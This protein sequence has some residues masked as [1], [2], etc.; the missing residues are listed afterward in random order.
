M[1]ELPLEELD[2]RVA[3][4]D[5]LGVRALRDLR[6]SGSVRLDELTATRPV[7]TLSMLRELGERAGREPLAD[8]L[9]AWVRKLT[10]RRVLFGDLARFESAWAAPTLT[11]DALSSSRFSPKRALSEV[12]TCAEPGLRAR[13]ARALEAGA[14]GALEAAR[15]LG[16]RQAEA[17]R[18]LGLDG[19]DALLPCDDRAGVDRAAELVLEKTATYAAPRASWDAA[20]AACL[21]RDAHRGWPAHLTSAWAHGLVRKTGLVDGLVL[22]LGSLPRPLG[23][24]SFARALARLGH[25]F[26]RA[27]APRSAPF[28][29]AMRPFDLRCHRR[30][31]LFGSLAADPVFCH[32]ALG[33]GRVEARDQARQVARALVLTLRLDA[34]RVLVRGM[35]T[36]AARDRQGLWEGS[37]ERALGASIPASLA[38]LVPR[39]SIEDGARFMGTLLG[40]TDR[41]VLIERFD[42]D[43]FR[44]PH[45][46]QALRDEQA[47]LAASANADQA[48]LTQ[49]VSDL[50]RALDAL[51]A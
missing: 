45:A 50:V 37:T 33:L 26:A 36:Q 10:L 20:V 39:S 7:S 32:R 23:A 27:S 28:S 19:V 4:A 22:E 43:W 48:T 11:D 24:A 9:A 46:A 42:E 35:F 18:Q 17:A 5:A 44:S 41:R 3:E 1:T 31:A 12:L 30:A 16:E 29:L 6:R 38:G 2:R 40:M 47:T 49:G 13:W 51:E 25:A 8:A 21:A 15:L 34:A 14:L